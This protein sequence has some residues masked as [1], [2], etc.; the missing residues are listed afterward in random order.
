MRVLAEVVAETTAQVEHQEVEDAV[1]NVQ[2][3][4]HHAK[5]KTKDK[6]DQTATIAQ[7]W[8]RHDENRAL[9]L[10]EFQ[11]GAHNSDPCKEGQGPYCC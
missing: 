1:G 11:N 7:K 9:C 10:S 4:A 3:S 2:E 8:Q 5:C 6:E